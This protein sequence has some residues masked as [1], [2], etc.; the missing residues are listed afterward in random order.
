ML[1]IFKSFILTSTLFFSFSSYAERVNKISVEGNKIIETELI[2]SHI[3]LKEGVSY[4]KKTIQQDVRQLFSLG[5]FDDIEVHKRSSKRGANILYKVKERIHIGEVEFKGNDNIKTEDLKELSLLKEHGFLSFDKFQKTVSAIKEKYKEKGY[6]LA[7]VSYKTEKIP[8]KENKFKLIIEIKENK[9]LLIKRI[10]FI[11]NRNIPSSDLKAPM[12]TKEKN[13]LSFLGSSGVFNPENIERDLQFIEYYYR[14]KGYLNVRVQKPEINI[15]PDKNFLYINFSISEGPRF[16]LG[17]VAFRGDEIVPAEA[18][19]D[20]LSLKEKEYF[21]L[22]SLQADIQFISTL[23]KNKGYAFAIVKPLFFP[24]KMEEDK[25]HILFKVEEG[26]IYKINR[27]RTSGNKETRDKVIL[28]RFQLKEGELY[29]ESKK[30]LTHQ[31]LQRLGHFE[32]VNLKPVK[33]ETAKGELDLLVDIKE[34]EKVGEA[35][36]AGGYAG[37][38]KLFI[39]G[40]FKKPNF[41]GLDHSVNLDISFSKYHELI[42]FNYQSPYFLDSNWN[43]AFD[44]FNVS[45]DTLSGLGSLSGLFASN[46]YTSYSQLNTG[47]AVSVGR[48]LT[49]FS[50]VFLKYRLQKQSLEYEPIYF[51]RNLPILKPVFNFLFVGDEEGEEDEELK[52]LINPFFEDVHDLEEGRGYNSS[53]SAILEYDKRNDRYYASKGFFTRLSV[54]YSGLGGNFNYTKLQGKFHHYYSPFWKLVIKNRLDYGL[55]FSNDRNK[56]VPFTELFLLGGPH[57]LKGFPLNS[58]GPRKFSQEALDYANKLN[59][60]DIPNAKANLEANI[61]AQTEKVEQF[62]QLKDQDSSEA[63]KKQLKQ[64]GKEIRILD[65][66]IGLA[67]NEPSIVNPEAFSQR[68]YGGTQMF[69]YSLELEFPLIEQAQLRGALFFDVGEVNNKLRFNLDDQLRA[70]IG[71]G[72]RWKSPFGPINLDWAWPY[73]PK[74]EFGEEDWAF[75]FSMGTAF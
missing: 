63:V 62:N 44:I 21:S 29:N 20:K 43:V 70:D 15:T 19:T 51:I 66:E 55:V 14:D 33:I 64:L 45:N 32:T 35:H 16:K 26:D 8:K 56:N 10:N 36:L 22:S 5:F 46:D 12:L 65:Y 73:N 75:Q 37:T 72:I 24:D 69:F 2:R 68:T 61:A 30:E 49:D 27:I 58:Q 6:Y 23:Y 17:E 40:G 11:G 47:F 67:E 39:K 38:T 48:H 42:T 34:R 41:L 54:E 3:Q 25:V 13:L 53:L 31:L 18:V 74:K 71:L 57:D 50:T 52:R 9:K 4:S 59:N 28:R 7:E 60:I 1:S